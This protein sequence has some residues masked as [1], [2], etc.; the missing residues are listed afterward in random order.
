MVSLQYKGR[1]YKSK[2]SL[3]S[4]RYILSDQVARAVPALQR[5]WLF[6]LEDR[7]IGEAAAEDLA[8]PSPEIVTPI[9]DCLT[10]LG[11]TLPQPLQVVEHFYRLARYG[12]HGLGRG[13]DEGWPPACAAS[14]AKLD[15]AGPG[16]QAPAQNA[17]RHA[18]L[19]QSHGADPRTR[20]HRPLA[21]RS[22]GAAAH[23]SRKR[24]ARYG[25]G[26]DRQCGAQR[27]PA[28]NAQLLQRAIWN[29]RHRAAGRRCRSGAGPQGGG[30]RARDTA[31][32]AAGCGHGDA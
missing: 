29:R 7:P 1:I 6:P 3:R 19:L 18:A 4:I 15:R 17:S 10:T 22:R 8:I 12:G 13:H 30:S 20:P 16:A 32:T 14:V 21:V 11:V 9:P 31:G 27:H 2:L 26:A 25:L 28:D 24:R 23:L 5:R